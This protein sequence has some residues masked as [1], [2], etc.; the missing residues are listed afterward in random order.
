MFVF[1]KK[2]GA[3]LVHVQNCWTFIYFQ[4]RR[5]NEPE[6]QPEVDSGFFILQ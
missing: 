6:V 3:R 1:A 5:M 4:S 2:S